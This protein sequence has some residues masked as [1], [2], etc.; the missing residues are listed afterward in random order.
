M[1]GTRPL[2]NNEIRLVSACFTGTYEVRNRS[3][4]LLGVSTGGRISEL[5]SLQIGDVWQNGKAVTDLLY[6][7]SIVKGGEVS[8]AVPVNTDGMR[9]ID[10]LIRWHREQY[11]T[12]KASH[13]LFPS[14]NGKGKQ[15]MTRRAAHNVLKDAF[16]AA[17]LNGHLATH[18]LRKS[19][20][21]RL[22]EQTGDVFTVQEMLGHKSIAT[23]QKYL[24]VNYASVREA[25]QKMSLDGELHES[26]LLGSS[27][28]NTKD[29]TLFLELALRGYDL[30]KLRDEETTAKARHHDD[31][32]RAT[33]AQII[34]IG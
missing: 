23:T 14:R 30:S 17:G 12:L 7:R 31:S 3:L 2:D 34:K 8:R 9:A 20:A 19:F 21:Q 1:K 26:G 16:L 25:L 32:D 28:K 5:L 4:F 18:S 22:Y 13:P 27:L 29:E 6:D 33:S 11:Q 10:D 24:G 15:R